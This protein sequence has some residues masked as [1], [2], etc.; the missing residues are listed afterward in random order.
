MD[1]FFLIWSR[2]MWHICFPLLVF[3]SV[4]KLVNSICSSG[5]QAPCELAKK[6]RDEPA[7]NPAA[8]EVIEQARLGDRFLAALVDHVMVRL[9]LTLVFIGAFSV[10]PSYLFV[11]IYVLVDFAMVMLYYAI[12]ARLRKGQTLGKRWNSIRVVDYKG[13]DAKIIRFLLREFTARG[14]PALVAIASPDLAAM[15]MLTYLP[16]FTEDRMALHDI[17]AGTRV[18]NVKQE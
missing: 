3:Y 1:Q 17:V 11:E 5:N 16:A 9:P 13:K 2:I 6:T 18:V 7:P 15:W 8:E 4:Y 10:R 12:F 14:I